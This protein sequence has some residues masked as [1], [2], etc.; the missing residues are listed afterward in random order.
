MDYSGVRPVFITLKSRASDIS[1]YEDLHGPSIGYSMNSV[2]F[3]PFDSDPK[4]KRV[5]FST[6]A[7]LLKI[8]VLGRI[9]V[10]VGTDPNIPYEIMRLDYGDRLAPTAHQP[11]ETSPLYFAISRKSQALGL[12]DKSNRHLNNWWTPAPLTPY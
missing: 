10:I 11:S 1:T 12:A 9:D 5:G 4:I 2:Y 6:E 3:E 8:A 7:Q